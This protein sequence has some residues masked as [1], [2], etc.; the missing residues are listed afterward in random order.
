M[1]ATT[2]NRKIVRSM[3]SKQNQTIDYN[4]YFDNCYT[5]D[6]YEVRTAWRSLDS[7]IFALELV[8]LP[9][10]LHHVFKMQLFKKVK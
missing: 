9:A 10:I 7:D 2:T 6:P 8:R 1:H 4:N 5:L 3:P